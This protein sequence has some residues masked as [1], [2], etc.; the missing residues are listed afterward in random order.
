MRNKK[1]IQEFVNLKYVC[2]VIVII[3]ITIFEFSLH[4]AEPTIEKENF[5]IAI[6][7][8]HSEYS[9]GAIGARGTREYVLNKII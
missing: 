4:S 6:D 3:L 8:G 2:F 9:P 5:I 7:T 1:L